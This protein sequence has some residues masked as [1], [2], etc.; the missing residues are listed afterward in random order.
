MTEPVKEDIRPY[1]TL[2][3]ILVS[4][5]SIIEPLHLDEETLA[6]ALRANVR[7]CWRPS[8]SR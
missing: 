1:L 2:G 3:K 6:S 4:R 8:G 5:I 7:L